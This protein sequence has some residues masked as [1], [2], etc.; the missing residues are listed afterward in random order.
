MSDLLTPLS[1]LLSAIQDMLSP[2]LIIDITQKLVSLAQIMT[3]SYVGQTNLIMTYHIM[4]LL[5]VNTI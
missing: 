4:P 3:T 1:H 2:Q 5:Y